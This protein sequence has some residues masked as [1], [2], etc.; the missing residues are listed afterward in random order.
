MTP[1]RQVLSVGLA[2]GALS[3]GSPAWA[4]QQVPIGPPTA[5]TAVVAPP[6]SVAPTPQP[7]AA[8]PAGR[9]GPASPAWLASK[10]R[11]TKAAATGEPAL[12]SAGR[13]VGLLVVVGTLGGAAVYLKRRGKPQSLRSAAPRRLSVVS[14]TRIGPKAHAVVVSVAGRQM[15]LGVTDASVKRLAFLD[16]LEADPAEERAPAARPV[17]S[18]ARMAALA[19]RAAAADPQQSRSFAEVLKTAFQK[20]EQPVASDA[21]SILAAETSDV[22][23]GRP[24]RASVTMLDVEGQAQGLI[25]RLSGPRA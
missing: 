5:P 1:L 24:A 4:E 16:E 19:V 9:G 10:P 11:A 2:A 8:L 7:T 15:L 17:Q 23:S 6:T 3:F 12:P 13:L 20:R 18:T 22:V 21:A 25:R 14:S